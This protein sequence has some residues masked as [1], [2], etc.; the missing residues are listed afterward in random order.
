MNKNIAVFAGTFDPITLGHEE[1]IKKASELFDKLIIAI[2]INIEKSTT[3]DV[4]LRLKMVKSVCEKYTNCKVVY[5]EGMVVDLMKKEGAK[6]YIR[7]V[8]NE[9][10]FDYETKTHYFNKTLY[11]EMTTF[12]IPCD[13]EFLDISST[14]V[15]DLIKSKKDLKNYLSKEVL[16]IL[17]EN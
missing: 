5:H 4:D 11:P 6:Y 15:R 9:I 8:R 2:C 14:K 16:K 10:D 17:K 7:G 13:K 12:F 3:F 1:I